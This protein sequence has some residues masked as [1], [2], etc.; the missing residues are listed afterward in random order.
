VTRA[1]KYRS[2]H[3]AREDSTS[4]PNFQRPIAHGF[5]DRISVAQELMQTF[6]SAIDSARCIL[7]KQAFARSRRCA[8]RYRTIL[9]FE[10]LERD[11]VAHKK[12]FFKFL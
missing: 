7:K 8:H 9:F 11:D 10:T 5:L 6:Q 2:S 3:S 1:R 4:A 12:I